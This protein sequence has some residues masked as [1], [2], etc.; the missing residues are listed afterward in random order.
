MRGYLIFPSDINTEVSCDASGGRPKGALYVRC[1]DENKL[2]CD[3]CSMPRA[4][5]LVTDVIFLLL[6]VDLLNEVLNA[7]K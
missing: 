1:S 2:L 6:V 3:R 4:G 7:C 5:I